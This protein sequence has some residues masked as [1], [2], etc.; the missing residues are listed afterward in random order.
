I[1]AVKQHLVQRGLKVANL[2]AGTAE[3]ED[4]LGYAQA[5][6]QTV[7]LH[8]A[9]LGV[10]VCATGVASSITAN[11]VP[12]VRAALV[13]DAQT[14]TLARQ[15]D[16]ANVLCLAARTIAAEQAAKILDAFLEGSRHE[17]RIHQMETRI[18]PT[19]FRLR[20]VDP[21][22]AAA[23]EREIQRQQEN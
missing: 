2:A 18:I 22:I 17:H 23:I 19:D 10:L 16:N 5:V 11:K 12:G 3:A 6:A 8:K 14:A 13:G 4:D 9:D 7:A 21:E 15:H 1:E 20:A